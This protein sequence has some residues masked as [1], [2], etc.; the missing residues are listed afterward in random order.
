MAAREARDYAILRGTLTVSE[1]YDLQV[2]AGILSVRARPATIPAREVA[3]HG[4]IGQS[5]ANDR[6]TL[7]FCNTLAPC[8]SVAGDADREQVEAEDDRLP[9]RPR[10]S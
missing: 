8:A 4:N 2:S 7:D 9:F 3:S 10:P 5:P 6:D 1:D